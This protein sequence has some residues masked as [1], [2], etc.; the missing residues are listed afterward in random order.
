MRDFNNMQYKH[1]HPH[2]FYG[3]MDT[4]N[5]IKDILDQGWS[6]MHSMNETKNY[7]Q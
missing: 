6:P 5:F 3:W 1:L 7:V 4:A 2:G